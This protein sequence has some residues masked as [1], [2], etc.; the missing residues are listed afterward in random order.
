M[1]CLL[2][3]HCRIDAAL[4]PPITDCTDLVGQVTSAAV[5]N[6][7]R[8]MREA[9]YLVALKEGGREYSLNFIDNRLTRLVLD[10][11][12]NEGLL[13]IRVDDLANGRTK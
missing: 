6:Q 8:K 4:F 1:V 13:P 7:I 11:M 5:A 3:V 10:Q 9:G 2:S 12:E